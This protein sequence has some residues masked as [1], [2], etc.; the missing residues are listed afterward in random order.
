MRTEPEGSMEVG[1]V[2]E[3]ERASLPPPKR[4][5]VISFKSS[6]VK[7]IKLHWLK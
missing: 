6:A 4:K 7:A 3:A 2:V 5:K 1:L